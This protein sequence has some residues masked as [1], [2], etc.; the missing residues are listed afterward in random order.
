MQQEPATFYTLHVM[1]CG[2]WFPIQERG[3]PVRMTKRFAP[4]DAAERE[5]ARLEAEGERVQVRDP[6]G[7][8]IA[9]TE[10]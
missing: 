1:R 10:H 8:V 4:L 9:E 2:D 6:R 7:R 3:V 5:R